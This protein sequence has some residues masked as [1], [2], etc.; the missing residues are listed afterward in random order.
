M[1]SPWKTARSLI[2]ECQWG[3]QWNSLSYLYNLSLLD[4]TVFFLAFIHYETMFLFDTS[5]RCFSTCASFN[6]YT[7]YFTWSVKN[8]ITK[9]NQGIIFW[10]HKYCLETEGDM[11]LWMVVL[12]SFDSWIGANLVIR[13]H[14]LF[15]KLISTHNRYHNCHLF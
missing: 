4:I 10:T 1:V 15:W 14:S 5:F 3:C 12:R 9:D 6:T 8:V 13:Y 7:A 2:N 11:K